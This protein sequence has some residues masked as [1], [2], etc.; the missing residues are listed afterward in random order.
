M[1]DNL[2]ELGTVFD[3]LSP[4][5]SIA[6]DIAHGGG[7]TFMIPQ[8]CGYTGGEITAILK[9]SGVRT[10]GELI[11]NGTIMFT[12]RPAQADF[13]RYLLQRA[14]LPIGAPP[15]QRA[16]QARPERRPRSLGDVFEFPFRFGV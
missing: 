13:A 12:V 8:D 15:G 4:A 2:L 1:F 5:L 14:G 10:W 9:A 6:G 7:T 16:H 3:W 11:V